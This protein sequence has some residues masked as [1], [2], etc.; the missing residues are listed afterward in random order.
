MDDFEEFSDWHDDLVAWECYQDY[1]DYITDDQC[2]S[3]NDVDN[4][5]S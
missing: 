1:L 3:D 2:I 4:T 5:G